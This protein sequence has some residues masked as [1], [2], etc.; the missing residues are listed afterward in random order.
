MVGSVW[1]VQGDWK[2]NFRH[3]IKIEGMNIS[4]D[5]TAHSKDILIQELE[6][7]IARQIADGRIRDIEGLFIDLDDT[8]DI[9]S[10]LNDG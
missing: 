4:D 6:I 1:I 7:R 2:Q 9:V 5:E 8:W 10:D 3:R